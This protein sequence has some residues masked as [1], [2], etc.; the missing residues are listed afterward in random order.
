MSIHVHIERLVLEGLDAR[1]GQ[2]PVIGAA[3]ERELARLLAARGLDAA[4]SRNEPH[5]PA[6]R[7]H[8]PSQNDPRGL[9]RQIGGAVYQVLN[10][11]PKQTTANI[12]A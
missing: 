6:G 9:G 11:S 5:L 12:S 4:S 10:P 2:G 8:L 7:L 1:P 3:V